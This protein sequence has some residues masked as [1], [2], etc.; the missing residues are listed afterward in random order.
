[1]R[2][3]LLGVCERRLWLSRVM[4]HPVSRRHCVAMA[5]RA[6]NAVLHI[7]AGIVLTAMLAHPGA[8]WVVM[9]AVGVRVYTVVVIVAMLL[10]GL[11]HS[12][13]ESLERVETERVPRTPERVPRTPTTERAPELFKESVKV[14][15]KVETKTKGV[16]SQTTYTYVRKVVNPRFEP[17][18]DKSHGC[19]PE[20]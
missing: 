8:L 16:Q 10:F 9:A 20:G 14:E 15:T 3:R 5:S 6:P 12:R 4:S 17:L 11:A 1:M 19:F 7:A 18:P 2:V 13:G